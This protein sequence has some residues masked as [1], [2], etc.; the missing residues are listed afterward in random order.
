MT[1]KTPDLAHSRASR[2]I[3]ATFTT[4]FSRTPLQKQGEHVAACMTEVIDDGNNATPANDNKRRNRACG[5][6]SDSTSKKVLDAEAQMQVLDVR[7]M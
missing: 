6:C 3:I 2:R 7:A 4:P 5:G 1:F